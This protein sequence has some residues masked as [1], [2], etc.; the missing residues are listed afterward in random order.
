MFSMDADDPLEFWERPK[1]GSLCLRNARRPSTD[2]WKCPCH[3][4]C[5]KECNCLMQRGLERQPEQRVL[6]NIGVLFRGSLHQPKLWHQHDNDLMSPVPC[7][8]DLRRFPSGEW[9]SYVLHGCRWPIEVLR[10]SKEWVTVSEKRKAP[11]HRDVEVSLPYTCCCKE[12]NCLMQRGLE[13]QLEQRVLRNIGVLFRGSLRQPKLWHQHIPAW[14]WFNV[15]GAML[16]WFTEVSFRRMA[17]LCSP[18]VQMTHWSSESF[19]R[20][21]H[22]VWE[23]EGALPQRCESLLAIPAAARSAI[24]WCSVAW[25]DDLNKERCE[26]SGSY[27]GDPYTKTLTPAWQWFNVGGAILCLVRDDHVLRRKKASPKTTVSNKERQITMSKSHDDKLRQ[28]GSEALRLKH[29]SASSLP[30]ALVVVADEVHRFHADSAFTV[31]EEDQSW[32][33]PQKQ[34]QTDSSWGQT[35]PPI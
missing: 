1:N 27:L 10:A 32:C 34:H 26:T 13:R 28:L 20:M 16:L 18:W 17:Q 14:Q 35:T 3:T 25:S 29:G 4:C 12:C 15:A 33:C 5:C 8:C 23:T 7:S 6:R 31:W 2:M 22:C 24:A 30:F 19:Q 11:F 9:R 21:G